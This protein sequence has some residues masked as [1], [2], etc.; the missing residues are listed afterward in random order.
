MTEE[1][2]NIP[3]DMVFQKQP[4]WANWRKKELAV[5]GSATSGEK[6]KSSKTDYGSCVPGEQPSEVSSYSREDRR[7]AGGLREVLSN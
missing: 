2:A 7:E 1:V 4:P 6:V 5:Y 3:R